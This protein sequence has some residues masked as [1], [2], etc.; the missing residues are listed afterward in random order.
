MGNQCTICKSRFYQ[1]KWIIVV[2]YSPNF[3]AKISRTH[4]IH[5]IKQALF[6]IK[7]LLTQSIER[8][9]TIITSAA[10]NHR[11]PNECME[12]FTIFLFIFSNNPHNFYLI[13]L[14]FIFIIICLLDCGKFN[15]KCD[16]ISYFIYIN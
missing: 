1:V 8:L 14:F 5:R 3:R 12:N 10:R 16:H 4:D 7:L 11:L 2:P 13:F 15:F 6:T 9:T